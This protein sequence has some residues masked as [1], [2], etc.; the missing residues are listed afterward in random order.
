MT[1]HDVISAFVDDEP[2]EASQLAEALSDPE[3]RALLIDL[4]ALRHLTRNGREHTSAVVPTKAR[5]F[6][7]R[8]LL[9]AA[10]VLVALVGGYVIGERR[11]QSTESPSST[12]PAATRVVEAP[13]SWQVIPQ[14]RSVR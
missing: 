13:S 3:G 10:A 11:S 1:P 6:E 12:P 9:A 8:P 4:I 7:I 14:Q 5:R 2:F